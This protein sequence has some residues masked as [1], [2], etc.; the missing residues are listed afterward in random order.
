[1]KIL[2]IYATALVLLTGCATAHKMNSIQ[3]GMTKPEIIAAIGSPV[4]VSAKGDREYLN[5]SLSE[6]GNQA[7]YGISVP[8]YVRLVNGQVD[9][10]GRLGDFDSTQTPTIKIEKEEIIKTQSEASTADTKNLYSELVQLKQLK[11][12]GIINNEE[13]EAEKKQLLEKY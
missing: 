8:Y 11:E 7:Y 12:E 4:S 3:I 9:S 2:F 10:Y 1:M 5:Y 6:T 13:F